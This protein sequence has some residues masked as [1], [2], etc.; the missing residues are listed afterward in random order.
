MHVGITIPHPVKGASTGCC[1]LRGPHVASVKPLHCPL[2]KC[3]A[4]CS[5][6]AEGLALIPPTAFG[7]VVLHH[8][9]LA[10]QRA[11]TSLLYFPFAPRVQLP[12]DG[13][14]LQALRETLCY[15]AWHWTSASCPPFPAPCKE[16][17]APQQQRLET[18]CY[19]GKC[20]QSLRGKALRAP[21]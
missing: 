11:I 16:Q 4:V 6:Q 17:L 10:N 21:C 14:E 15:H 7:C 12:G 19:K 20:F 8:L 2:A 5:A 18:S 9:L 3:R 13:C 1:L